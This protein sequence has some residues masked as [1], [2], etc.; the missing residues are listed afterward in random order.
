MWLSIGWMCALPLITCL[1]FKCKL[2]IKASALI[3]VMIFIA[4]L[5]KL[6]D[7]TLVFTAHAQGSGIE[8]GETG[9]TNPKNR[10]T[11]VTA[12]VTEFG[13]LEAAELVQPTHNSATNDNTPTFI[14]QD[15]ATNS[16]AVTYLFYLD[17]VQ[18]YDLGTVSQTTTEFELYF[19]GSNQYSLTPL[20]GLDDGTYTWKVV[21]KDAVGNQVGT[22]NWTFTVDTRPPDFAINRIEDIE[23]NMVT[24][25]QDSVPTEPFAVTDNDPEF[26]GEGD[27]GDYVEVV[28]TLADGTTLNDAFSVGEDGQWNRVF[29][30]LP[31]EELIIFEFTITDLVGNTSKLENVTLYVT[32]PVLIIPIPAIITP[33]SLLPSE[34]PPAITIPIT[35]PEVIIERIVSRLPS[36]IV[37]PA[38]YLNAT[39]RTTTSN[40]WTLLQAIIANWLV[41]ILLS[42]LTGMQVMLLAFTWRRYLNRELWTSILMI[43]G[44]IPDGQ[45]QG[46]AVSYPTQDPIG[47]GL[48]T[49]SGQESNKKTYAAHRITNKHGLFFDVSLLDGNYRASFEHPNFLFPVVDPA[50]KNLDK[51]HFYTGQEFQIKNRPLPMLSVFAT[52]RNIEKPHLNLMRRVLTIDKFSWPVWTISLLVTLVLPSFGNLAVVGIYTLGWLWQAYQLHTIGLEGE[53]M[54]ANKKPIAKVILSIEEKS[55]SPVEITQ[56][57]QAGSYRFH[58]K[59]TEYQLQ[60]TDVRFR[61]AV[62]DRQQALT[63]RITPDDHYHP[64]ILDKI[65]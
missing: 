25:N 52:P 9:T 34:E 57:N 16:L 31:R 12:T 41:L 13:T 51:F 64:I 59:Q 17:D 56:T 60:V 42:A 39:L 15:P 48:I 44:L 61:V 6:G 19:D 27:P 21:S 1:I 49:F 36:M 26:K 54:T 10:S 23:T 58:T 8:D 40:F 45:P 4:I 65:K 30:N 47:Y 55:G 62:R 43:V 33:P 20:D 18:V 53:T 38:A 24:G 14:W 2:P 50:P 7:S 32:S 63:A 28:I 35:T 3:L 37:E 5:I 22:A 29:S 46:I 11:Q